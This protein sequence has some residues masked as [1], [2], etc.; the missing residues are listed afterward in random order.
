MPEPNRAIVTR[1]LRLEADR[2]EEL[3]NARL[4]VERGFDELLD[5]TKAWLRE[6]DRANAM[7]VMRGEE[8]DRGEFMRA[9]DPFFAGGEF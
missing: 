9:R 8:P 6:I 7:A 3:I 1:G 4:S 2:F 5:Y